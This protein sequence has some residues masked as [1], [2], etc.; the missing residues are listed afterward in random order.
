M[1]VW[2]RKFASIILVALVFFFTV[3][4]ILAIWDVIEI[5][6]VLSKTFSSLLVI[7]TASAIVLFIFAVVYKNDHDNKQVS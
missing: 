1:Y 3:I 4:S 6:H 5:E 7:F 2:L